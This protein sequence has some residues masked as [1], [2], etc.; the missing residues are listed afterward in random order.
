MKQSTA[1]NTLA[2]IHY[3]QEQGQPWR[4]EPEIDLDRQAFLS[5]QRMITPD[6]ERGRYPFK[7]IKLGRADIEWLL[8]THEQGRGPVDWRDEQQRG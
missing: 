3:W 4:T 1:Q 8:V 6:I 7:D 5:M 2:W